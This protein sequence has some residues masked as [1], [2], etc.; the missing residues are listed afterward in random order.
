MSNIKISKLTDTS[1]LCNSE[2]VSIEKN[3]RKECMSQ[4]A[5]GFLPLQSNLYNTKHQVGCVS[6]SKVNVAD[7]LLKEKES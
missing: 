5:V 6:Y 3:K 2:F 7:I 4:L 1:F